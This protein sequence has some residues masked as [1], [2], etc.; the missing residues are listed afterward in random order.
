MLCLLES[1][2]SEILV[3]DDRAARFSDLLIGYLNSSLQVMRAVPELSNAVKLY[4]VDET[5]YGSN[6]SAF[7]HQLTSRLGSLLSEM[8]R[9]VNKVVPYA[10]VQT[11]RSDYPQFDQK[12]PEGGHMQQDAD[13]ALSQILFT[14]C[15]RVGSGP[16][17]PSGGVRSLFEGQMHD[18]YAFCALSNRM[19]ISHLLEFPTQRIK[20]RLLRRK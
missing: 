13:E 11:L 10:F 19:L 18:V 17:V 6:K 20:K 4:S 14:V 9:T 12:S 1:K 16:E 2:I 5:K 8:D 3:S 7:G 15:E